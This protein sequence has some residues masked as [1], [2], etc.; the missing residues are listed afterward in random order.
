MIDAVVALLALLSAVI[1]LAHAVDAYTNAAETQYSAVSLAARPA[2]SR[3]PARSRHWMLV[4]DRCRPAPARGG[5]LIG[6]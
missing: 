2:P 3:G 6:A 1:F 5:R 4:A